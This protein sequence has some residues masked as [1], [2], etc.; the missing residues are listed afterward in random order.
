MPLVVG[1]DPSLTSTGI[2][3]VRD[4]KVKELYHRGSTSSGESV[5]DRSDRIS[6]LADDVVSSLHGLRFDAMVIEAPSHGSRF[7][8]PHERAGLWWAIVSQFAYELDA[9][10]YEVAPQS[11]A[12]YATGNGGSKKAIVY[13]AVKETYGPLLVGNPL[14]VTL[15]NHD[16][17]DALLLASM[18]S[19]VLGCPVE[20][21]E[22]SEGQ[23]AALTSLRGQVDGQG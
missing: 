18:G 4:G 9:P 2:A 11:R 8:K 21:A 7:G 13:A 1:I 15:S 17:G 22:P 23:L 10:V 14:N 12:K 5:R 16:E 19:R 3:L 20:A 6:G